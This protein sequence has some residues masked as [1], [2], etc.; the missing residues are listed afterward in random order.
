MKSNR[1]FTLVEL[2]V[3]V[4]LLGILGTVAGISVASA[5]SSRARACADDIDA[6]ISMCRVKC[7]TR[8]G[9]PYIEIAVEGDKIVGKY[10]EGNSAVQTKEL[11]SAGLDITY[12][13]RTDNNIEAPNSLPLKISFQ[14]GDGAQRAVEGYLVTKISV[15][16]SGGSYDVVLTPETGGHSVERGG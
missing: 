11:G 4:L 15:A 8:A 3:V 2:I 7:L 16:S 5:N 12:T 10:Y 1:G 6:F 14:R 9:A 13:K